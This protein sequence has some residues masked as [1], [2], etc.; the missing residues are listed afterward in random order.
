MRQKRHCRSL[1]TLI[2]QFVILLWRRYIYAKILEWNVNKSASR[3]YVFLRF[4]YF[5]NT[6]ESFMLKRL[7]LMT[8]LMISL[9]LA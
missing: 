5:N 7:F 1:S 8:S 4:P 9:P 6:I 2:V 3:I